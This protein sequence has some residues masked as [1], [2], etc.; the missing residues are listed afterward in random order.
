MTKKTQKKGLTGIRKGPLFLYQNLPFVFFLTFIGLVYIA[1][2][3]YAEKKIRHI[4]QLKSEIKEL[5]T[6]YI[7]LESE[8]MYNGTQS[9]MAKMVEDLKIGFNHQLPKRVINPDQ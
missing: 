5:R 3:H 9:Q 8:N 6:E 1:N 7:Y 2:V 4:H